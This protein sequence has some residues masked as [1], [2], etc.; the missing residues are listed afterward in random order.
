MKTNQEILDELGKMVTKNVYDFSVSMF[1]KILRGY[2]MWENNIEPLKLSNELNKDD[3][4]ILENVQK[5]LSADSMFNLLKIFEEQ[6]AERPGRFRLIYEED[7]KQVD[8][9]EISEMLKAEPIIENGWIDRFS[10]YA[11]I[12]REDK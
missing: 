6:Q 3:F 2:K 7:G 9:V 5:R 8:L 12:S 1:S 11:K 4:Y 10:E